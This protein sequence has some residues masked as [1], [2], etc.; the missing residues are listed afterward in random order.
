MNTN[1]EKSDFIKEE[2]LQYLYEVLKE[3]Q[4]EHM[5]AK[6]EGQIQQALQEKGYQRKEV[7]KE[8][9]YLVSAGQVKK[10]TETYSYDGYS[11]IGGKVKMK[12]KQ[13]SYYIS[14]K[15]IDHIEGASKF[16]RNSVLGVVNIGTVHGA[17]AIGENSVAI[18]NEPF[19]DAYNKL[20]DLAEEIQGVKAVTNEDKQE[21]LGDIA[22]LK[23]QIAKR[24]PNEKIIQMAWSSLAALS[25][26]EGATQFIERIKPLIVH[27]LK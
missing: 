27:F 22:T 9:L 24:N 26:I 14:D 15:G 12:G 19:L 7:T 16:M 23:G 5:R 21:I 1:L 2:I 8:L 17:V 13:I 4:N 6:P 20:T 3:A 11:H 10:N 18:V 25:T